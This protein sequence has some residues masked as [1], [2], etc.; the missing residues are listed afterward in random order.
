[1]ENH[2]ASLELLEQIAQPAFIVQKGIVI[3]A[4]HLALQHQ[5]KVDAAINA[6]LASGESEYAAFTQGRLFLTLSI[7]NVSYHASV[8]RMED[9]DLFFLESEF[10][11]PELRT[12]AAAAQAL[13]L[14]L[15]DA[16]LCADAL[17]EAAK[18]KDESHHLQ[19]LSRNLYRLH[20]AIGNMSDAA[21]YSN[22]RSSKIENCDLAALIHE[23]L[24]KAR[25]FLSMA[26][27]RLEY[28]CLTKTAFCIADKEK[29]ER[30]ILN[31]LSNAAKS[32]DGDTPIRVH[33]ECDRKYFRISV[34]NQI[35]CAD[36]IVYPTLFSAYRREPGIPDGKAGLGLG[37]T[38]ARNAAAA[39]G[40]TLLFDQPEEN[41]VRFTLSIPILKSKQTALRS[42]VIFPIDYTGGYD[43]ALTELSDILPDSLF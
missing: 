12:L 10:S 26:G 32:S 5:V 24:E 30:A 37:L 29:L 3:G 4:N 21:S 13:R 9:R 22:T 36:S 2:S 19:A 23:V 14:P 39:H 42:P 41:T 43:H 38:I 17:I 6:M 1:M 20:R 28:D 27:K 11:D 31:L 7:D 33:L 35:S 34:I 8:V 18:G 15:S 25:E 16:M 40:G